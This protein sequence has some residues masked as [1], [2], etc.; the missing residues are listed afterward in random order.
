VAP[1]NVG[2]IPEDRQRDGLILD[3][4]IFENL[5][6]RGVG[7]RRGRMPW[8]DIHERAR[9]VL[10]DYDVRAPNEAARVG[11]L[12][13]GNQQKVVLARELPGGERGASVALVAENP[14]RGLDIL[15][16]ASVHTRLRAARNDGMAILLY[17]TDLDEVLA[18]ADRILV[19]A[20]G[21]VREV[22]GG[23]EQVGRAMLALGVR[24]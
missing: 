1:A 7:E 19:V 14:T 23:R 9:G 5:A 15:A 6:L 12:S 13:G 17:S 20:R 22:A 16:T 24:G 2:F 3:F 21:T 18:L 8:R 11:T 4:A 10:V